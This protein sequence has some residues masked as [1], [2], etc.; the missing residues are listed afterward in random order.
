MQ[1][2]F[3]NF[4]LNITD[5][6]CNKGTKAA[7]S[8]KKAILV[9]HPYEW[10]MWYKLLQLTEIRGLLKLGREFQNHPEGAYCVHSQLYLCAWKVG[11]GAAPASTATQVYCIFFTVFSYKN[12]QNLLCQWLVKVS[13]VSAIS[14][15]QNPP[16][17]L[18][19]ALQGMTL[20]RAME[21]SGSNMDMGIQGD[22]ETSSTVATGK[23]ESNGE[24]THPTPNPKMAIYATFFHKLTPKLA[25]EL[26]FEFHSTPH[27]P[28]YSSAVCR[29]L[30]EPSVQ[31]SP[32]P[33]LMSV[34][35]AAVLHHPFK[36]LCFKV[37]RTE[38]KLSPKSTK[39]AHH[40]L[41]FTD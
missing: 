23:T 3:I 9:I 2:L 19:A 34:N 39:Q 16:T 5:L 41:Y 35:P 8:G 30:L 37:L 10:S 15:W 40:I 18:N 36:N 27:P 12:K 6:I 29:V 26:W 20:V 4:C 17:Y 31:S 33:F 32:S 38:E 11:T 22:G 1:F 21:A 14:H 7:E 28:P 25:L 24:T 13:A